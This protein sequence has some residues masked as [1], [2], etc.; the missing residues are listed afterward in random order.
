MIMKNRDICAHINAS[1][2]PVSNS[3][4]VGMSDC[5]L[6]DW[7]AFATPMLII[8]AALRSRYRVIL[9]ARVYGARVDV[10]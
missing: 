10:P 4:V 5:P 2:V 8:M 3:K 7:M 9:I 6:N 1:T